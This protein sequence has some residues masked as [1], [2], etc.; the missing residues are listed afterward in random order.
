MKYLP[1]IH[2]F[3]QCVNIPIPELTLEKNKF[4][5][6]INM[7]I[8]NAEFGIYLLIRNLYFYYLLS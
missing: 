3:E 8:V 5:K 7:R 4:P 1:E 6:I 2:S